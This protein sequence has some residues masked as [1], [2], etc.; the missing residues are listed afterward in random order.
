[1]LHVLGLLAIALRLLESVDDQSRRGR[2]D[3]NGRLAVDDRD[4]DG[5]AVSL[6]LL[7]GLGDLLADGAGVDTEWTEARSKLRSDTGLAAP[8]ART[9]YDLA[10]HVEKR[11]TTGGCG[12]F[13]VKKVV[14]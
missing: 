1:M 11:P 13:A 6:V 4:L 7:G 5:A 10:G 2:D 9:D 8:D 12:G 14:S 3:G